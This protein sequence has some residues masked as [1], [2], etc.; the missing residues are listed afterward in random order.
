MASYE[1]NKTDGTTL[2][3]ISDGTV[4]N[5][6]ATLT[7]VG[8]NVVNYGPI[9][10]ENFL[11]LLENFANGATPPLPLAG[12]T[13][14]DTGVGSLKVYD[15]T[16]WNQ[17]P[18]VIYNTTA[19]N[20]TSGDLWFNT[21]TGQ[22]FVKT[23]SSYTL[24]GPKS[25]ANTASA[26]ENSVNI[27]GVP[28]D[29]SQSIV[30]SSTTTYSLSTGSYISGTAFNGSAAT[31]WSVYTGVAGSPTPSAVVA[32]DGAGDIWYTVGHGVASSAR[33]A[34][35][36]EK[37]IAD[38][39]YDVGTVMVVNDSNE[40]E[41]R[42]SNIGERAIGVV[43]SKPAYLM[44]SELEGGVAIALKGRVPVKVFGPIK[45]GDR[46]ESFSEG[47]ATKAADNSTNVFAVALESSADDNLKINLIE[48]VIL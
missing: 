25:L 5:T 3:S 7:F 6:H 47:L 24:I 41:V 39:E 32:R 4:D 29:G 40:S 8:K 27:N 48:S 26:L 12:Q 23:G 14:Y 45:K 30:V 15:A 21:T 28:F 17:L 35:L 37:Y 46:L 42:S 44:N 13:W 16:R 36:A 11:Y 9:Q 31:S 10:N 19:T 2:T 22:L 38:K 33:Y 43:S 20:Q 1:L 18:K 34:D